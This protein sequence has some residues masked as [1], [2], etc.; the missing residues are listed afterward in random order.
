VARHRAPLLSWGVACT[1]LAHTPSAAL[2]ALAH[3]LAPARKGLLPPADTCLVGSLVA[4][5]AARDTV[6][7]SALADTEVAHS[8]SAAH[9]LAA[10][11]Y[12]VQERLQCLIPSQGGRSLRSMDHRRYSLQTSP[13]PTRGLQMAEEEAAA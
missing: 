9:M 8:Q 13:P 1:V 12:Q 5:R 3:S 2:A 11:K 4:R 6:L 10:A 7:G